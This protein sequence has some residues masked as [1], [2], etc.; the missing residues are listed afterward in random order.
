MDKNVTEV[1]VKR[2]FGYPDGRPDYIVKSHTEERPD[3]EG[4]LYNAVLDVL[5][6][7]PIRAR[8]RE[9]RELL[10]DLVYGDC[11]PSLYNKVQQYLNATKGEG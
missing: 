5:H 1:S 9:A 10:N 8:L 6:N 3:K 11:T 4:E 7:G 2:I